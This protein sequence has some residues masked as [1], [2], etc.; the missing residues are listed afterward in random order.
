MSQKQVWFVTGTSSG[1]GN[2]LLR[3]LLAAGHSVIA[4]SRNPEKLQAQLAQEYDAETLK[5]ALFVKLDVSKQDEVKAA[6]GA[7]VEKFGEINVVINN[8]GY[9]IVGEIEACPIEEGRT[10]YEVLFWG[11]V[12][13]SKEAIR[14]FRE[15]N[16]P[17]K[18]GLIIN[19]STSGGYSAQPTLSF[20]NSA[21]FAL[22]GFTESL[23]KEMSPEW[24]IRA[25]IVEPGGF[26]TEWR[27]GNMVIFPQHPAY[28][29]TSP[30]G[31]YR[32]MLGSTP[33]IGDAKKAGKILMSLGDKPDLPLRIQLG[34]DAFTIVRHTA[35]TTIADSEKWEDFSQSTNIDGINAKEYTKELLKILSAASG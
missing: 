22:E 15:V 25:T 34:S 16:S 29:E 10:L 1:M 14:V 32:S 26:N 17:G 19:M 20:Y 11:P 23:R 5:R 24:N 6:F 3:E 35:Q 4:T 21:K 27:G 2:A 9:A 31:Q 13:I 8:A 30:V 33:F 28:T 18:G 12:Y 7:G